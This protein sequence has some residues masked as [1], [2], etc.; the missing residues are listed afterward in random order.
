MTDLELAEFMAYKQ[1]TER[2]PAELSYN[3]QQEYYKYL[4][5]KLI[6]LCEGG[7][8]GDKDNVNGKLSE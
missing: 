7:G 1:I 5:Y 2:W 3:E 4:L 8:I 6:C